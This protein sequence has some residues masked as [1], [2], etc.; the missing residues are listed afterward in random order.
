MFRP[1]CSKM[2]RISVLGTHPDWFVFG[3]KNQGFSGLGTKAG[4]GGPFGIVK[5]KK[6]RTDLYATDSDLLRAQT[7]ADLR[8]P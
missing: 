5:G 1:P 3:L 7:H 6:K 8:H 4:G 2:V